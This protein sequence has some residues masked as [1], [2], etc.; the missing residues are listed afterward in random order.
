MAR[1]YA[2]ALLFVAGCF[3]GSGGFSE[4]GNS[5]PL[6]GNA[7]YRLP[8]GCGETFDTSQGNDGDLCGFAG[9]DHVGIQAFA[10]DFAMPRGTPILAA[11]AGVVTLALEETHAGERCFDGCP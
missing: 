8:W 10:F 2:V 4:G 9:G 11:R 6:D 7:P 3:G 5:V 1:A